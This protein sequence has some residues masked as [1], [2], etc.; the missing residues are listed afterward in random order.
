ML[1]NPSHALKYPQLFAI[2]ILRRIGIILE[3]QK[4]L[5]NCS[6]YIILTSSA[7]LKRR[8]YVKKHQKGV[9]LPHIIV[10]Y[11]ST[12]GKRSHPS[13]YFSDLLSQ[14]KYSRLQI[15]K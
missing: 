11:P 10:K 15:W 3:C 12:Q 1:F 5:Q 14:N 9:F 13:H 6:F 8:F 2:D 7:W 4:T